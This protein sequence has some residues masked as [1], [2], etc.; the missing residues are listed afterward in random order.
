MLSGS[1][2]RWF[3]FVKMLTLRY[4]WQKQEKRI[5]GHLCTHW[6]EGYLQVSKSP[7]LFQINASCRCSCSSCGSSCWCLVLVLLLLLVVVVVVVV[8]VVLAISYL[9][10]AKALFCLLILL[11]FVSCSWLK[12]HV[13]IHFCWRPVSISLAFGQVLHYGI[14]QEVLRLETWHSASHVTGMTYQP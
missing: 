3:L 11:H 8:V 13:F 12:Q 7:S 4:D 6:P 5:Q 14:G 10:F 1:L 9:L 2:D